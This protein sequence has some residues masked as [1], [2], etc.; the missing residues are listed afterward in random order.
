MLDMEYKGISILWFINLIHYCSL[1]QVSLEIPT[2]LLLTCKML[3]NS[4]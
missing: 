4:L 3:E 2:S 1:G